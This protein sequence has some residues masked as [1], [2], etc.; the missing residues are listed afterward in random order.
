MAKHNRKS[1]RFIGTAR[2]VR[3]PGFG[4]QYYFVDAKR[5]PKPRA[6]FGQ[7]VIAVE[8]TTK[9]PWV[10]AAKSQ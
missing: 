2:E 4:F 5:L 3:Y 10:I 1:F 6:D 9:L 8:F 7:N